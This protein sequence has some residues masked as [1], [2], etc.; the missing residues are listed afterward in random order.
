ML[1]ILSSRLLQLLLQILN[2][3]VQLANSLLE[4]SF[5]AQKF[6]AVLA[7][8]LELL[9]VFGELVDLKVEGVDLLCVGFLG[10]L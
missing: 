2:V 4:V 7:R 6:L 9:V 1:L 3:Q 5:D 10:M 8:L